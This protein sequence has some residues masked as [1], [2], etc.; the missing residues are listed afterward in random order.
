M[1][2]AVAF[3]IT[4]HMRLVNRGIPDLKSGL[5]FKETGDRIG[6]TTSQAIHV[7]KIMH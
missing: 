2:Y 4:H 7:L 1:I 6:T 5:N 3:V